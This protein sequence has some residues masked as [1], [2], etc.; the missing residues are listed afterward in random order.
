MRASVSEELVGGEDMLAAFT[1][2]PR[3]FQARLATGNTNIPVN[4]FRKD[5]GRLGHSSDVVSEA[6]TPP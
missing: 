5:V 1:R 4:P 2:E 3:M 6:A